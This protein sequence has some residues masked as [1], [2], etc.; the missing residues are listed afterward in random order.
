MVVQRGGAENEANMPC[1]A[2]MSILPTVRRRPVSVTS[3]HR[4]SAR[5]A[6]IEPGS[7]DKSLKFCVLPCFSLQFVDMHCRRLNLPHFFQT[8]WYL[9]THLL[10]T[11]D[12]IAY[13]DPMSAICPFFHSTRQG[14]GHGMQWVAM[15]LRGWAPLP[16][17]PFLRRSLCCLCGVAV[18]GNFLDIG[19]YLV[20]R[21]KV[22]S[23]FV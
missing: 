7:V 20:S 12:E 13:N 19:T 15:H 6:K 22:Y 3:S 8:S 9:H 21:S 5:E 4:Y 11:K 2:R 1:R 23:C 16:P 14:H 18:K 17:P 10:L